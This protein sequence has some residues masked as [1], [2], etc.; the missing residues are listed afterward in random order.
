MTHKNWKGIIIRKELYE[1]IIK[2][3]PTTYYESINEFAESALK[4]KLKRLDKE[5]LR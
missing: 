3:L 5:T 1:Q 2:A 4:E